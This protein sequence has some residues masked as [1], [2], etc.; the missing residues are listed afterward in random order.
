MPPQSPAQ[1]SRV[2]LRDGN[3][4]F[5]FLSR[6][7]TQNPNRRN[8]ISHSHK[9]EWNINTTRARGRRSFCWAG[10]LLSGCVIKALWQGWGSHGSSSLHMWLWLIRVPGRS[11][12]SPTLEPGLL[13]FILRQAFNGQHMAVD[14]DNCP[15][16]PGQ[17][18]QGINKPSRRWVPHSTSRWHRGPGWVSFNKIIN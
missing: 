17:A 16:Y 11:Q 10:M 12:V 18:S 2:C 8:S 13:S 1:S 7:V 4:W 15:F 5:T 14:N 9:H 6:L 3:A